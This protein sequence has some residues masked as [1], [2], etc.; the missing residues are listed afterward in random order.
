MKVNRASHVLK[1][2]LILF[3]IG[4]L[5]AG[6]YVMPAMAVDWAG[7]YPDL[8]YAKIPI[9][10]LCEVLLVL[11]LIGIGI[12]MSLLLKF[13]CGLT[14]SKKFIR[15]LEW[16]VG[17]CIVASIGLVGLYLFLR[18]HGGPGPLVAIIM[19]AVIFI[20]WIV[21]A[22]IMLIRA[23]VNKALVYKND[24]DLTV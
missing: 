13:D 21:A 19:I 9:L 2:L 6:F 12:I 18:M 23:I 14:F 15:G 20:I 4:A 24:Y 16:L 1:V 5:F 10:L 3:A 17:L 8:A 22:V 11:L 7:M